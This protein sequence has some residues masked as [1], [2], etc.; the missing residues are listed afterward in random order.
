MP[1]LLNIKILN[2]IEPYFVLLNIYYLGGIISD[3]KQKAMAYMLSI[4]V[5]TA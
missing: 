3:I 2:N 5:V 1:L 4:V